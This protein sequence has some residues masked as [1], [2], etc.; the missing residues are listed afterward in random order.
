MTHMKAHTKTTR[1]TEIALVLF[2]ASF[3]YRA[4]PNANV[5]PDLP[6][7]KNQIDN[8]EWGKITR[9]EFIATH[10]PAGTPT[11]QPVRPEKFWLQRP[12]GIAVSS[13]RIEMSNQLAQTLIS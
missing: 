4:I 3:I 2:I 1:I 8:K 12:R 7:S 10:P 5:I 9:M 11:L 6:V 13:L